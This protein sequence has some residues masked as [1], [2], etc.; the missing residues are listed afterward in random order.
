MKMLLRALWISL[1]LT[2]A[3]MADQSIT[4]VQQALKDQGFYYGQITGQKDA[5]TTAAIRRFQI[6]NGL[7]ITGELNDETLNSIR[8][9]TSSTAQSTPLPARSTPPSV[10]AAPDASDPRDGSAPQNRGLSAPPIHPGGVPV[11]DQWDDRPNVGR[12]LPSGDG[13]FADT[14]FET[15]PLEVQRKVIA[16]AQRILARRG[17]FKDEVDGA[18]GP[19]LEFS[20][21]A[22]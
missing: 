17:L 14:P 19:A 6:R 21:R 7:Q 5:D 11:P 9:A 4:E 10:A 2:A 16:D 1:A 3:A 18:F 12:R 15:A 22:Y 13:I 8:S 20:L